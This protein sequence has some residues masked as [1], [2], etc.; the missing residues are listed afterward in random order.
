MGAEGWQHAQCTLSLQLQLSAVWWKDPPHLDPTGPCGTQVPSHS[1]GIR[2][3]WW[4]SLEAKVS[5]GATSHDTR[6]RTPRRSSLSPESAGSPMSPPL[7]IFIRTGA[8][9]GFCRDTQGRP[10]SFLCIWGQ[11]RDSHTEPVPRHSEV[12][13]GTRRCPAPSG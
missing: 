4:D 2:I 9:G 11:L 8:G 1:T 12:Q 13:Q 3:C 6:T 7:P 5:H 10:A